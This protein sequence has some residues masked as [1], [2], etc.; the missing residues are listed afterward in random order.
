MS[1]PLTIISAPTEQPGKDAVKQLVHLIRGEPVDS[2]TFSFSVT[3]ENNIVGAVNWKTFRHE[4]VK[5]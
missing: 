4:N 1:P 5:V 3:V 2:I